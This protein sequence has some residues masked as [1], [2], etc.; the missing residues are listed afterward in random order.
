MF[1]SSVSGRRMVAGCNGK[2]D[3]LY[4]I[5]SAVPGVCCT[6]ETCENLSI[7]MPEHILRL[8][9]FETSLPPPPPP[10][11]AGAETR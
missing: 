6:H 10:W 9:R 1:G 5:Q 11:R 7:A 8:S 3:F 2:I 4:S